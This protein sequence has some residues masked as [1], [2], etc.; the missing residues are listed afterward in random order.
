M[1]GA[2]G[3]LN[4]PI[5]THISGAKKLT[6]FWSRLTEYRNDT[7]HCQM[8]ENTIPS[9]TIQ[10]YVQEELVQELKT[11]FSPFLNPKQQETGNSEDM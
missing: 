3:D 8:R 11:I 9:R 7:A 4:Q 6:D 1:T 2:E 5:A 10:R